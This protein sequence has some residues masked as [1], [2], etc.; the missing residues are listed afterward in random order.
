MQN[1]ECRIFINSMPKSGTHLLSRAVEL[2]HYCEHYDEKKENNAEL[3]HP[4]FLNYKEVKNALIRENKSEQPGKLSIPVGT[5]APVYVDSDTFESWLAA[6]S[7]GRYILGHV[8]W[9]KN[10]SSLLKSLNYYHLFII[11]DPRAVLA[12][13]L[14]FILDA[15]G[16]P[17]KHF[18]EADFKRLSSR[19]RLSLILD[20]G[21]AEQANVKVVPFCDIFRSML[22]WKTEPD[23]LV[24]HFEDLIGEKGGGTTHQQK[25]AVQQIASQLGETFDRQVAAKLEKIYNPAARTFRTGSIDSWKHSLEPDDIERVNEYC[26]P[27]C[28]EAGY[29]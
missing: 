10:L 29:Q 12:S 14:S 22:A 11:R 21:Y 17:K 20:G 7:H 5:L 2:F 16:M 25:E 28:K 24:L 4:I 26:Q 27:L 3:T 1:N 13:L 19:Q 8:A 15:R 9:Q 6:V 23:C 18:L